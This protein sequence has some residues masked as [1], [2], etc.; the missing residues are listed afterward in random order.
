MSLELHKLEGYRLAATDGLVGHVED[1]YFD[2]SDWVIRYLVAG[3]AEHWYDGRKVLISPISL[4]RSD[5][6]ERTLGL[7]ITREQIRSSPDI[8]TARPV[9][10]QHEMALFAH[11][12]YLPYW[13]GIDVWGDGPYPEDL[14]PDVYHAPSPDE[15]DS[16]D[17][18]HLRSLTEVRGYHIHANDGDIGK[19]VDLVVD[20]SSWAVEGLLIETGHWWHASKVLIPPRSIT[21]VDWMRSAVSVSLTRE[22]LRDGAGEPARLP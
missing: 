3:T 14:Y 1:F 15:T 17:D 20:E 21:D 13:G 7:S 4:G 5:P 2:D 22:A 6:R 9:A 8:D 12:N 11:Y 19:V 16:R 10:R 18:P